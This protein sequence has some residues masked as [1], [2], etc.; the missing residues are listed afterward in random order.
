MGSFF[1][2]LFIYLFIYFP[3]LYNQ[4]GGSW[5]QAV[6]VLFYL[7]KKKKSFNIFFP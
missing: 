5:L 7:K 2:L 4:M 3:F 1:F 6:P